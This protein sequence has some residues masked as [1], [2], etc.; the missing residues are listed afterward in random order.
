MKKKLLKAAG[1]AAAPKLMLALNNPKKAAFVKAG[2]WASTNLLRQKKRSSAGMTAAK[3]LG[4]AAIAV[5]LGMLLGRWMR[6]RGAEET[7]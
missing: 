4:A 2:K 6:G 5:P 3:G 7:R 1:M